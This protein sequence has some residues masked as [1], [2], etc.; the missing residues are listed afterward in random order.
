MYILLT[1]IFASVSL[2]YEFGLSQMLTALT[3]STFRN[4][5]MIIGLYTASLGFG[6]LYFEFYL[7]AKSQAKL[8]IF[9]ELL[10]SIS[11]LLAPLYISLLYSSYFDFLAHSLKLVFAL[12]PVILIGWLSGIELP[13]LM[14][15]S[16]KKEHKI[17]FADFAGMFISSII[18]YNFLL[19]KFSIFQILFSLALMNTLSCLIILKAE[20]IEYKKSSK[21]FIF[22]LINLILISL[23][24]IFHSDILKHAQELFIQ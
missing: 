3:G 15:L 8:L 19:L 6:A 16:N 17:L 13:S 5:S 9:T 20:R 18:F 2:L 14:A 7:K 1:F 4:Y 22:T 24:L 12:I 21:L 11:A 23:S 10:L